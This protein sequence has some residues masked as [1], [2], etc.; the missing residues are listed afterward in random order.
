MIASNPLLD[1]LRMKLYDSNVLLGFA[2]FNSQDLLHA[3]FTQRGEITI[4]WRER[5]E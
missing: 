1:I 5:G 2:Y 3:Q 4:T